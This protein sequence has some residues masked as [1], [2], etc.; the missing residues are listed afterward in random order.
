MFTDCRL[1]FSIFASLN[2]LDDLIE[3][4]DTFDTPNLHPRGAIILD[5]C[6]VG[7][8][9]LHPH[10]AVVAD[11]HILCGIVTN[12]AYPQLR[13]HLSLQEQFA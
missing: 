3:V 2:E 10:L 13:K 7:C 11:V 6:V 9:L 1:L 5:A 12:V 8:V 4:V